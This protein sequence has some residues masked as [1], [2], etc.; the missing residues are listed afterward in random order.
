[1]VKKADKGVKIEKSDQVI[2]K[3]PHRCPYCGEPVSYDRMELKTGENEILCP[4]CRKTY[5]KVVS[6]STVKRET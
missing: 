3:F 6:D 5:I 4:S 2:Q 1:M